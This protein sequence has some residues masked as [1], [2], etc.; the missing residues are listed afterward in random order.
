[1]LAAFVPLTVAWFL[2]APWLGLF[3]SEIISIPKQ[4]WRPVLVML[5][6]APFAP[7]CGLVLNA[8]IILSLLLFADICLA[9]PFGAIYFFLKRKERK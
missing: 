3:Q 9:C 6:V 5:F 4:L 7:F 1:M 8:P 2:L